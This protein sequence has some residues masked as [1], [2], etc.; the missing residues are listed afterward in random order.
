MSELETFLKEK[1]TE[2]VGKMG[3]EAEVSLSQE[4]GQTVLEINPDKEEDAPL[5]IGF[6][7]A[8][9]NAFQVILG[10]LAFKKFGKFEPFL[11]ESGGYRKER[12]EEIRARALEAA[13]K[14]KFLIKEVSFPA[15]NASERRI[16][17]LTHEK[18]KGVRTESRGEGR[19]RHV[20]VIP[21]GLPQKDVK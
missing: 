3:L 6:H 19:E 10:T 20:V 18:E 9:L 7:G 17:H 2:I 16:I 12:E 1:T 14:A 4:D 21:G 11:V 5:L 13:D 8:T 15:M